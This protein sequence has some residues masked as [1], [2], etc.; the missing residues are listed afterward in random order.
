[1]KEFGICAALLGLVLL[2]LSTF[3]VSI[4]PSSWTPEKAEQWSTTK[5]RLHNLSFLV[6]APAGSEP[7]RRH[8]NLEEA[9]AEYERVKETATRLQAELNASIEGPPRVARIMKWSGLVLL[10]V[11]AIGAYAAANKR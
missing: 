9:K 7:P 11:G 2:V 5:D 4:Y 3:W 6:N 8:A 1:M 10:A